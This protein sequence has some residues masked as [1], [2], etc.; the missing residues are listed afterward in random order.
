MFVKLKGAIK[1]IQPIYVSVP[2][3]NGE[4]VHKFP[5]RDEMGQRTVR[6]GLTGNNIKGALRSAGGS[7]ALADIHEGRVGVDGGMSVLSLRA[8]AESKH[9]GI[10]GA[11]ERGLDDI[12]ELRKMRDRN[13]HMA[14]FGSMPLQQSA[15]LHVDNA[16]SEDALG[17]RNTDTDPLYTQYSARQD[18]LK[19]SP[20]LLNSFPE[21]EVD[22]YLELMGDVKATSVMRTKIKSLERERNRLWRNR[23][24][25]SEEDRVN[26][27]KL[28][29][30]IEELTKKKDAHLKST[31]GES[32]GRT[33]PPV[34]AIA[35]GV[36]MNHEM[37]L[38]NI[39]DLEFGYFLLCLKHFAYAG[40]GASFG[41]RSGKGY[42][43]TEMKYE[44][45]ICESGFDDIPAGAIT[46]APRVFDISSEHPAIQRAWNAIEASR[47]EPMKNF[48]TS[49]LDDF[50]PAAKPAD[51]AASGAKGR[52]KG[53]GVA[54]ASESADE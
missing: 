49:V 48:D 7:A 21:D 36:V 53:K 26:L 19:R 54:T 29:I 6:V 3:S 39:N 46:I 5:I 30:E 24:N 15:R 42:G 50:R 40:D 41:G 1:A 10:M 23:D 18:A 44:I 8:F 12:V 35:Q 14:L 32:I 27:K 2:D 17:R 16:I 22:E 34:D 47:A 52:A 28:E 20:E 31:G 33:L 11:K 13:V 9:G 45:T 25:L 4:T 38:V 43:Q 37:R 51:D